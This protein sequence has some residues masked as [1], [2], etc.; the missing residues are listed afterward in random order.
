MFGTSS[1]NKQRYRCV[2]CNKTFSWH[3]LDNKERSNRKYFELFVKDNFTIR[4]LRKVTKKSE[5][6][7]RRII[8]SWLNRE[9]PIPPDTWLI[10]AKYLLF[11]GT[12][13]SNCSCFITITD[14]VH[15]KVIA[16]KHIKRESYANVFPML[17]TL[18]A[19]GLNPTAITLDGHRKVTQAIKET[20]PN[21]IIQR[22]LFHIKNQGRMWIRYKPKTKA[23]YELKKLIQTITEIKTAQDQHAFISDF[24]EWSIKYDSFIRNLPQTSIANTD[25]KRTKTLIQNAL[26]NMFH[27]INDPKIRATNNA[28]EGYYSWLK[29]YY[30]THRGLSESHKINY[31]KWYCFFKNN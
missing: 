3:R 15:N 5:R 20:W 26:I 10:R 6:T 14:V 22:C 8:T 13:F 9:P 12:Y 7:L 18:H 25:L 31:L 1:S 16:Y 27:F 17:Q 23:G 11:D 24:Y 30:L 19:R 2:V 21:I 29:H 28:I 4:Q